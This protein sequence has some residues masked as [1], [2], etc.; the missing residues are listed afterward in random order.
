MP[1]SITDL[2]VQNNQVHNL[3]DPGGGLFLTTGIGGNAHISH[4]MIA[5]NS[6]LNFYE[7]IYLNPS[8]NPNMTNATCTYQDITIRDNQL[9]D[10][11]NGAILLLALPRNGSIYFDSLLIEQNLG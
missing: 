7:G 3:G 6:F 5:Q 9:H 10:A 11:T 4:A 8:I 2:T 1:A